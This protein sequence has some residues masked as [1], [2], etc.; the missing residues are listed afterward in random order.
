VSQVSQRTG[1]RWGWGWWW[2]GAGVSGGQGAW[3]GL[4][5]CPVFYNCF[6][7]RIATAQATPA[8]GRPFP[9]RSGVV[10][11]LVLVLVAG[12]LAGWWLWLVLAR[13]LPIGDWPWGLGAC[14]PVLVPSASALRSDMYEG[15]FAKKTGPR[16]PPRSPPGPGFLSA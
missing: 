11:V 2:W 5:P 4:G 8:S 15:T 10:G 6:R 12:W 14:S 3:L 9:A 7:N 16:P 13:M 1:F